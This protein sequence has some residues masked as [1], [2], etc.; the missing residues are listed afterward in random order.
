MGQASGVASIL[1]V[2]QIWINF[3]IVK[4]RSCVLCDGQI[5]PLDNLYDYG[6]ENSFEWGKADGRKATEEAIEV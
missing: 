1:W 3:S 5:Y 6:V 2:L 4:N